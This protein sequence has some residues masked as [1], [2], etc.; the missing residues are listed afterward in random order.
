[1][2]TISGPFITDVHTRNYS[3]HLRQLKYKTYPRSNVP[4]PYQ[5]SRYSSGGA[6]GYWNYMLCENITSA[7]A[8][9]TAKSYA[10]A[11]DQFYNTALKRASLGISLYESRASFDM[12][13]KRTGQL[14]QAL[15]FLK[16]GQLGRVVTTLGIERHPRT[17]TAKVRA[18]S[19][20]QN[21]SSAWLEF[22]FGWAPLVQDVANVVQ[23]LQQDFVG[24]PI[25]AKVRGVYYASQPWDG[26]SWYAAQTSGVFYI[27]GEVLVTN[28]NVLLAKSLGL[29]N[30]ASIAWDAV[31]FSFVVDWFIPV[32]KFLSSLDNDFGI[33][34]R[35]PYRGW[36][37]KTSMTSGH[38]A[39]NE[40]AICKASLV[41]GE[42]VIGAMPRPGLLDRARVPKL[43]PW[44][45]V[46]SVSLLVQQ[47]KGTVR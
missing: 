41:A 24:V 4:L 42:R 29:T 45:A 36:T 25:K 39:H 16:R 6:S 11:Y 15:R 13:A 14:V 37:L 43:D 20:L 10:K 47:W 5:V 27:G 23:V 44:L 46:T 33:E 22:T 17:P 9:E 40:G 34:I 21:P 19:L 7:H 31:P 38:A 2:T 12:V 28:P 32:G 30:P 3:S 1:M 35:N 18:R 8:T 26:G